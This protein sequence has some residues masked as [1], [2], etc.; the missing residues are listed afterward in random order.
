[1]NHKILLFVIFASSLSLNSY[2]EDLST[3]ITVERTVEADLPVAASVRSILPAIP[4]L[5]VN[6]FTLQ[7]TQYNN[8]SDFQSTAGDVQAPLYSKI[9]VP[10]GYRGYVWAGYLPVYNLGAAAGYRVID[11]D[12]TALGVAARFNGTSYKNKNTRYEGRLS[13]NTFGV[14][15]DFSHNFGRGLSLLADASYFAAGLKSPSLS[16]EDIK[17]N[18]N[19]ADINVKV[20][21]DGKIPYYASV[22]YAYFGLGNSVVLENGGSGVATSPALDNRLR[23]DAGMSMPFNRVRASSFEL[24]LSADFL[25]AKGVEWIS[26]T[27]YALS[28]RGF[29]G[30]VSAS[31]AL[32]FVSRQVALKLGVK[33]DIG[34]NSPVSAF[35]IAPD[36]NLTW[37]PSGVASVYA[38]LGGGERFRTLVEQYNIS[39]FAPSVTASAR[40]Y[41]PIDGRLGIDFRPVK[42]LTAGIFVGYA[43]TRR[44]PMLAVVDAKLPMFTQES[45]SGWSVGADASYSLRRLATLRATARLYPHGKENLGSPDALDR[46]KFVLNVGAKVCPIEKLTVTAGYKLRTNRQYYVKMIDAPSIAQNMRAISDLTFGGEYAITKQ[47]SVFLQLE[48]LLN[49][50]SLIIPG[51]EQ[52]GLHGLLG[53]QYRF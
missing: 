50:H 39:A 51:I 53:A 11:K 35:H 36:V 27:G 1:M 16:G 42:N 31:P 4:S 22:A 28:S 46:A 6:T 52:Q 41:T 25:N 33:V 45:I 18:L 24:G 10:D 30:M 21:R 37:A 34:I 7:P 3:E 38:S 44:M 2:A 15:A 29:T 20:S 26:P 47:L 40:S 17:Q 48:N 12:E 14:K 13:D 5:P 9:A 43:T 19:S 8:A 49:R 32:R 23:V